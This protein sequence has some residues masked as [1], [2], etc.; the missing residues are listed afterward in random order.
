MMMMDQRIHLRQRPRRRLY[1]VAPELLQR[2]DALV[3]IDEHVP[4]FFGHHDH[5]HLLALFGQRGQQPPA[6]PRVADAQIGVPQLELMELQVHALTL[7]G[8]AAPRS[9]SSCA[10]PAACL[11]NSPA[12]SRTCL[13]L[14]ACACRIRTPANS[15]MMTRGCAPI[16]S[17][18]T[19]QG[20]PA[21]GARSGASS[22]PPCWTFA[23]FFS[24][25]RPRS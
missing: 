4:R 3:A 7:L 13:R 21:S 16:M 24:H 6:S 5:W 2:L 17:C 22:G 14:S 20:A 23:S 10:P 18:A 12:I 15:A 1:R 8:M 25:R 19:S 9:I 11:A